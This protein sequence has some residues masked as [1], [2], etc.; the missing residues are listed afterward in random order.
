MDNLMGTSCA[1]E[2]EDR[3]EISA[4]GDERPMIRFMFELLKIGTK[5]Q[6][7]VYSMFGYGGTSNEREKRKMERRRAPLLYWDQLTRHS[8]HLKLVHNFA[9]NLRTINLRLTNEWN[10]DRNYVLK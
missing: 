9:E 7:L 1:P 4:G 3:N 2:T 6:D 8:Q 5:H 10:N